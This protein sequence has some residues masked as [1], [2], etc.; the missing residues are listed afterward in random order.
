MGRELSPAP[1]RQQGI[2][3]LAR[4]VAGFRHVNYVTALTEGL[5]RTGFG[6]QDRAAEAAFATLDG[7][8]PVLQNCTRTLAETI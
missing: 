7:E 3:G 4:A 8:L 6:A 1:T 5:Q 2:H